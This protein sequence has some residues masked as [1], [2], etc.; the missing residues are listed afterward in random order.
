MTIPYK[1]P[2][3]YTWLKWTFISHSRLL[4][5]CTCWWSLLSP[6]QPTDVVLLTLSTQ[7]SVAIST[8]S[9]PTDQVT[10]QDLRSFHSGS[11]TRASQELTSPTTW[12]RLPW[13]ASCNIFKDTSYRK[14]P[15]PHGEEKGTSQR[16]I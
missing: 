12:V 8:A 16:R 2:P 13:S 11:S 4:P 9:F 10:A 5:D 1:Q 14:G 7:M 15:N 3:Q 6:N